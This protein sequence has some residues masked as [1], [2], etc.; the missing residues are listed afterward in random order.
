MAIEADAAPGVLATLAKAAREAMRANPCLDRVVL[1]AAIQ[2]FRSLPPRGQME[3]AQSTVRNLS[4]LFRSSAATPQAREERRSLAGRIPMIV[5]MIDEIA[6]DGAGAPFVHAL[7]E[8]LDAEFVEP[9]RSVRQISPFRVILILADASLGNEAVLSAYLDGRD[10]APEKVLV[11]TSRGPRPFRIAGNKLRLGGTRLP[12][13]H[14]MADGFPAS[15]LQ[16]SSHV[17]LDPLVR[18]RNEDGVTL[19]T[20]RAIAEEYGERILRGAVR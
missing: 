11:S 6:G 8:W 9:F 13:L 10:A 7:A 4:Q 20:R 5:V 12:V 1:T 17:R 15:S 19:S 2:G 16:V 18:S 3:R 14:V